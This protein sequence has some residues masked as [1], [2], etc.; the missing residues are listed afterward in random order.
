MRAIGMQRNDVRNI[1]LTEALVLA[2][3]G[4]I[5]GLIVALGL[6]GIFSMIPLS[7]E[8]PLQLFLT[9][10]T[11][12][13]PIVLSSILST[14]VIISLV[15]LASAYLPARKAAKLDPAVALRT[16]Y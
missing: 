8:S 7:T 16:T 3:S 4:A 5:A 2:L 14:L 15:T 9:D 6:S 1:F 12:A 10:N 13:F 11:F